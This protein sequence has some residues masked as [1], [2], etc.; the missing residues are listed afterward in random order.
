MQKCHKLTD[1]LEVLKDL[2][3]QL[4]K[5]NKK[6]CLQTGELRKVYGWCNTKETGSRDS[7][8][9]TRGRSRGSAGMALAESREG[10][11][12][13][14]KEQS[15]CKDDLRTY[16]GLHILLS[17]HPFVIVFLSSFHFLSFFR[18]SM[19]RFTSDCRIRSLLKKKIVIFLYNN[20]SL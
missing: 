9:D 2:C 11:V 3:D 16:V 13:E 1:E 18:R 8:E 12:R 10:K 7:M 20:L 19:R 5:D 6:V 4:T 15:G 14:G 17:L